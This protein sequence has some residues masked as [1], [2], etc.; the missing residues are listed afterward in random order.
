MTFFAKLLKYFI[1][2]FLQIVLRWRQ[3]VDQ[4]QWCKNYKKNCYCNSNFLMYF[5]S[6]IN[7]TNIRP[8]KITILPEITFRAQFCHSC[9]IMLLE[10]IVKKF[11]FY[12][13]KVQQNTFSQTLSAYWKRSSL[14]PWTLK[15]SL[16]N[17]TLVQ[18]CPL[19]AWV[20]GI[21]DPRMRSKT[22]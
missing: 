2:L 4:H 13:K 8:I 6:I 9:P 21:T 22:H 12:L 11:D 15:K 16:L 5:S 10:S 14:K 18:W 7:V 19:W 17:W 3:S 1:L 20:H